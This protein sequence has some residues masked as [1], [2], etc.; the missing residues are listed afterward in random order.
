[1][2]IGFWLS[3]NDPKFFEPVDGKICLINKC[4]DIDQ[5]DGGKATTTVD[6]SS[7]IIK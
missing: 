1:M 2:S 4:A 5:A 7:S 6:H 3:N